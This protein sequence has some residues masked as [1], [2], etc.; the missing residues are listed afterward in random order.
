MMTKNK[1]TVNRP[2]LSIISILYNSSNFLP[3]FIQSLQNQYL[4]PSTPVEIIFIV[5]PYKE[6][7]KTDHKLINKTFKKNKRIIT[8]IIETD[9]NKGFSYGCNLGV[10]HSTSPI[11][12]FL[13]PDTYLFDK[14]TLHKVI[15]IL[16]KRNIILG[17]VTYKY[18][19]TK[20]RHPSFR[21]KPNLGTFLFEFTNLKKIWPTNPYSVKFNCLDIKSLTQ[22][23]QVGSI[24]GSF[25]GIRKTTF[26]NIGKFDEDFFLYLEDLEFCLRAQSCNIPIW[27]YPEIRIQHFGGGSSVQHKER[28]NLRQWIR[29]RNIF[30]KK[31]YHNQLLHILFLQTIFHIDAFVIHLA[32]LMKK[33]K[34]K[35]SP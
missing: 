29:S 6:Y 26:E 4:P 21:R 32:H 22:P 27:V 18:G 31:Y 25:M 24:S 10:K 34:L 17:S 11:L 9:K 8:K 23:I 2:K 35:N 19:T 20:S 5:Y 1:N 33:L 15:N 7:K 13:N 3:A 14:H 12:L 28:V 16:S 30:I